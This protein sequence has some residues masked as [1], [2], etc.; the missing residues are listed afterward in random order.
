MKSLKLITLFLAVFL[1]A[2]CT[3]WAVDS[4]NQG[5]E[6][7]ESGDIS[8]ARTSFEDATS[9]DP[10]YAD[11]YNGLGWCDLLED[12][13]SSAIGNFKSALSYTTSLVD[14]S[15]GAAIAATDLGQHSD[16][17]SYADAVINSDPSYLFLH[18]SK[19]DIKVIR[20]VKAKSAAADG[21]F[22]TALAEIQVI[23]PSFSA[24]ASTPQGQSDIL[25][26]IEDLITALY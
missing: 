26:K 6:Y 12:Y 11:A 14:A 25:E 2:A 8:S 9:W 5:W 22:S 13:L 20:L 16:A 3:E 21:D 19:V 1:S 24:D 4:T 7:F 15:A 17:V 18:Y 10:S 23:E